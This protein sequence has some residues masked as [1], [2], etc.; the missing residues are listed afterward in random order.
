MFKKSL[1]VLVTVVAMAGCASKGAHN[2]QDT[3][4]PTPVDNSSSAGIGSNNG[5]APVQIGDMGNSGS[6]VGLFD[7][8]SKANVIYFSLDSSDI[9]SAGQ[10]VV[11]KFS[12]YLQANPTT[13]VRIEGNTDERGSREYNVGLG[14]RRANAVV[15]A[16]RGKGVAAAQLSVISYGEERPAAQGHDESAWSQNRRAVIVR[17]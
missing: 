17:Q 5:G 8:A 6:D 2:A 7:T 4:L 10:A 11:D 16:L 15:A 12:K 1:I 9:D 13:K 14:E 3:A